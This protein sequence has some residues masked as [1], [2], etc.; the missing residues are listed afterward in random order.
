[1]SASIAIMPAVLAA[2]VDICTSADVPYVR[3]KKLPAPG[4]RKAWDGFS[5]QEAGR[6]SSVAIIAAHPG[7][8]FLVNVCLLGLILKLIQH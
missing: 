2:S 5:A 7:N 4:S 3:V 8:K 1:M 6:G